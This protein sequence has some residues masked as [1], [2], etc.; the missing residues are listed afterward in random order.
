MTQGRWKDSLEQHRLAAPSEVARHLGRDLRYAGEQGQGNFD[1]A[2]KARGLSLLI[3][4]VNPAPR[5]QHTQQAFPGIRP[6]RS[7]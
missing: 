2:H 3:L 6:T 1:G 5:P 7:S 4:G